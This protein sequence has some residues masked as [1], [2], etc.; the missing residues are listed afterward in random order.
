LIN[1]RAWQSDDRAADTYSL[2]IRIVN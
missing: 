1:K 2:A